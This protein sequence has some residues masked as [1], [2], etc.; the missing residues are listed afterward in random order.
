M[1]DEIGSGPDSFVICRASRTSEGTKT[2]VRESRSIRLL[3]A[4][5]EDYFGLRMVN[6]DALLPHSKGLV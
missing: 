5:G 2:R 6:E 3:P 4:L 1:P